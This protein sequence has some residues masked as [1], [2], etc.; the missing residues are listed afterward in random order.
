MSLPVLIRVF[1]QNRQVFAGE[2]D[3]VVELGRQTDPT[4]SIHTGRP[5]L[6]RGRVVIA[7]LDEQTVSRRHL[8]VERLPSGRVRL[9]NL[10]S[11]NPLTLRNGVEMEPNAVRGNGASGDP[12]DRPKGRPDR[13]NGRGTGGDHDP[14]TG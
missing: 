10:S 13:R 3:G 12:D 7:R 14:G 11:V 4:E 2:F 1:E 5:L 9:K 6:D 8:E